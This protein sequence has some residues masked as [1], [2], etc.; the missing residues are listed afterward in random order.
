MR[1]PYTPIPIMPTKITAPELIKMKKEGRKVSM[2]TAY[3]YTMA[4]I[5]DEAGAHVILVGDSAAWSCR[6]EKTP[7][8]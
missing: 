7:W 4:R 3:D 5:L 6:G 1:R 8:G 2:L